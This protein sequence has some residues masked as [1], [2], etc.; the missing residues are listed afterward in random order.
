MEQLDDF[1]IRFLQHC[2]PCILRFCVQNETNDLEPLHTGGR[3]QHPYN[4]DQVGGLHQRYATPIQPYQMGGYTPME[5][6]GCCVAHESPRRRHFSH[7]LSFLWV[8]FRVFKPPERQTSGVI[9]GFI[10]N[11][12]LS[13]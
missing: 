11:E 8:V 7:Q 1:V 10:A 9:M 6:C 3:M 5:R 12:P 2:L 13:L 4:P